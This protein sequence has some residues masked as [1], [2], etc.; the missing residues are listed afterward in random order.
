MMKIE[1][2]FGL[3]EKVRVKALGLIGYINAYWVQ[4]N[5][6]I[7]YDVEWLDNSNKVNSRYFAENEL[8]RV[9]SVTGETI[10]E[11][12]G[13]GIKTTN[14]RGVYDNHKKG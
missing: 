10:T 1:F 3:K 4:I 8:E 5:E 13:N 11:E 6:N 7:Q 9:N 14:I 2:V 12:R